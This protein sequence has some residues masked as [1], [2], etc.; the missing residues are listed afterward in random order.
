[1][2]LPGHGRGV[3][4][5]IFRE[6]VFEIVTGRDNT[7]VR[8]VGWPS[9][10]EISRSWTTP[11]FTRSGLPLDL[12]PG[13]FVGFVLFGPTRRRSVVGFVLFEGEAKELASSCGRSRGGLASSWG[14]GGVGRIGFVLWGT[15]RA[16]WLRLTRSCWKGLGADWLRL[17]ESAW[18][19]LA[20]SCTRPV[21]GGLA[22]SWRSGM[23]GRGIGFVLSKGSR[24]Q[25]GFVFARR[26]PSER[27]E[28]VGR[29]MQ[30]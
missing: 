3:V 5:R 8:P 19:E 1:M 7:M 17:V 12:F 10:G 15:S 13:H 9:P 2:A 22:S 20:S 16:G 24:D 18:G 23:M 6:T 11:E 25:I 26:F 29:K 27:P 28:P 30:S 21:G 14:N 4:T